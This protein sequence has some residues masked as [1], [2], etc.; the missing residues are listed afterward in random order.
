MFGKLLKTIGLKS[1]PPTL[2][3][4]A[5]PAPAPRF[6]PVD[7]T[8]ANFA[9]VVL[10]SDKLAVVDF[11]AEWCAPCQVV[12]AYVGFLAAEYK[13]RI[14]VAALDTEENPATP[15]QYNIMGLPTLLFFHNGQEVERQVGVLSY[16][17]LRQK[18]EDLLL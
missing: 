3:P 16:E 1:E 5:R 8:D 15:E 6:A 11:W 7:V 14:L 10:Q 12:S 9:E 4:D 13:E 17:E 2:P 18:V